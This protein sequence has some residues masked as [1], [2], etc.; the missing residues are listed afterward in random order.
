MWTAFVTAFVNFTHGRFMTRALL[1]KNNVLFFLLVLGV[2]LGLYAG[3]LGAP[4]LPW[5][6]DNNI[7]NNAYYLSGQW[8]A[9][10]KAPYYGLYIPVTSTVWQIL[11][12][13]GHGET[14][15]FRILNVSLHA[16]NTVFVY[17]LARRFHPESR[18]G[19]GAAALIFLVHPVQVGTVA[20]VS[21]GRDLL[22]ATLTLAAVAVFF[23]SDSRRKWGATLLFA[24]ALLAKP[25]IV[26]VPLLLWLLTRDRLMVVWLA[27]SAALVF[28]TT[29]AQKLAFQ[30]T[31]P[32]WFRPFLMLDSFG[33]QLQ[34]LVWP[35]LSID[36][37]RLPARL[38]ANPSLLVSTFA[39]A[40]LALAVLVFFRKRYPHL[41]WGWG[42][43]GLMLPV[44]GI[45][46]T[47]FQEIS[48]VVDHYH[49]LPLVALCLMLVPWFENRSVRFVLAA[50]T[51][52]WMG[53]S[54]ARI[55]VWTNESRFY[56]DMF[57]K[58]PNSFS[59]A[60][61]LGNLAFRKDDLV[62][63]AEWYQKALLQRPNDVVAISNYAAALHAQKKFTE[64]YELRSAFTRPEVIRKMR[65]NP[66]PTASLLTSVGTSAVELG[67][68]EEG[69]KYICESARMIPG[70][71]RFVQN[72]ETMERLLQRK[73][74]WRDGTQ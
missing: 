37:G 66:A 31:T 55:E 22:A 56:T 59:A 15:P 36:Y 67:H 73:C 65:P 41:K 6:D 27:L 4:W 23:S 51:V 20:W 11:F 43:F 5:D 24:A 52:L 57:E 39:T 61:G 14:W 63:A 49:Y 68:R 48:T 42:W 17:S 62:T 9:L 69:F 10:W 16:L 53:I 1:R 3:T 32:I 26:T 58:N 46:I 13:V 54:Y 28:V 33:F 50:L 30:E 70:N 60:I 64:A 34:K 7:F 72:A 8:L 38:Y 35:A 44:S 19:A 47:G 29:S 21:G 18:V 71:K 40:G 74:P 12:Q 45:V 2:V 25:H